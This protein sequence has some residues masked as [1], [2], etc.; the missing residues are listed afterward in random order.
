MS[1]FI[2]F[3]TSGFRPDTNPSFSTYILDA[4]ADDLG[5][6]FQMPE[7]A[8]I[9]S[10][11]WRQGTLTGT[12][13]TLRVGLQG[14][15]ATTGRQDGTYL[16]GATN[17]VDYTSWAAGNNNTFIVHTLPSSVSLTRGQLVCLYLDPQAVG[18][19][20]ASNNVTVAGQLSGDG[21]RFNRPYTIQNAAIATSF[22][23]EIFL[24]RSSSK[25]YGNPIQTQTTVALTNATNPD[26]IGLAFTISSTQFS[27]FEVA[28][29]RAGINI[30]A[31]GGTFDFRINNNTTV[32]QQLSF[33]TDQ[34]YRFAQNTWEVYFNETTLS[35]LNTGTEYIASI[36]ATSATASACQ[37]SYITMPTAN[38]I[39]AY[40]T[41]TIRWAERQGTGS[42][43]FTNS[44]RL[45]WIQ[46]LIKSTAFTSGSG[47]LLVHPGMGGGMRG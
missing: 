2:E 15:S 29:I 9:T 34:A 18:T 25:T 22:D 11:G 3:P 14:V 35:T 43:S 36:K 40:S 23:D 44:T 27:T 21:R 37:P 4:N 10:I 32:L 20:N 41:E 12:P 17:Y 13:G 28:G 26:E 33:D 19:W 16:G 45:P 6:V 47:G 24:L 46:L 30:G 42:W 31:A 1:T 38:D 5:F 8:T 7:A 39:T